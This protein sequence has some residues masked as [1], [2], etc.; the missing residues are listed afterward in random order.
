MKLVVIE[1]PFSGGGCVTTE[2]AHES[3]AKACLAHSL[4]LGEAPFASHVT[5][6]LVLDDSSPVDRELGIKA[7]LAWG[8][9]AQER[10]LYMDHGV[11]PGMCR[12]AEESFGKGK[13]VTLRWL[14]SGSEEMRGIGPREAH[15]FGIETR[16]SSLSTDSHGGN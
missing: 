1:S 5:Y 8:R 14:Y 9:A 10:I 2:I 6:T 15:M 16:F 12:G 4:A 7:G 3:Y 11:S 13:R